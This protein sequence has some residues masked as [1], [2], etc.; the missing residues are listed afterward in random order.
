MTTNLTGNRTTSI[1]K[2]LFFCLAFTG[3]LACLSPLKH[4][5][6]LRFERLAYGII[7]TIAALVIT[8]LFLRAEKKSFKK[9]PSEPIRLYTCNWR[10]AFGEHKL[11]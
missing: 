9:P 1:F 3:L 2:A 8:W 10:P 5:L 6:P 11:L 4:L 7:G